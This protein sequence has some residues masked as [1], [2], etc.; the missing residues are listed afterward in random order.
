M[1]F[2]SGTL[3]SLATVFTFDPDWE[4]AESISVVKKFVSNWFMQKLILNFQAFL[5]GG[6]FV[7]ST[8]TSSVPELTFQVGTE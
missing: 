7:L 1:S 3:L 4:C 5:M 8:L 6:V 2:A